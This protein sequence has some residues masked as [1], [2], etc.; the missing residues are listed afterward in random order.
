LLHAG[1]GMEA[2]QRDK[3]ERLGLTLQGQVRYRCQT[4]YRGRMTHKLAE[5]PKEEH[6]HPPMPGGGMGG[7][8]M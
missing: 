6:E 7:M 1:L 3:L 2:E 5:A 4:A 8:H